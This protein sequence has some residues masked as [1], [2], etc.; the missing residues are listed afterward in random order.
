MQ[1]RT[2]TEFEELWQLIRV[3]VVVVPIYPST[4]L[5]KLSHFELP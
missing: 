2:H 4:T 1:F 3:K 5:S